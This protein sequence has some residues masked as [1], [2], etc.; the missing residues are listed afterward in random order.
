MSWLNLSDI[1]DLVS[2]TLYGDDVPITCVGIDSRTIG[3]GALFIA[4]PGVRFD[5]HD[6]A[7][8]AAG[9]GAVALLVTHKLN[10]PM[11]QVLVKDT[12]QALWNLACEWRKQLSLRMI[13]L[14]G[15]NGKTTTKEMLSSIFRQERKVLSTSGNLNNHIGVPLTLLNLRREHNV[16]V[17]EMGANHS[18]EIG[19]LTQL[20]NP[21][22][23][24]VI[25]AAEAHLEGFGSVDNV[26]RA[27]GELF[28]NLSPDAI[29]VINKDSP[30]YLIWNE[31][32]KERRTISFG[33]SSK[34][35]VSG[36]YTETSSELVIEGKTYPVRLQLP[37]KYNFYNAMAAT[38]VAYAAGI[39]PETIT[40]GL[41][42]C[43]T[44]SGRLH[45]LPGLHGSCLIDDSYNANPASLEAAL[46]VLQS[47][48]QEKWLVLGN[49]QELGQRSVEL[50]KTAG[51]AAKEHGIQRLFT[52]GESAALA[53]DAFGANAKH[54]STLD[55]LIQ[56]LFKEI[57]SD[58]AVL[59]KGSRAAEMDKVVTVLSR[60]DN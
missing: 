12:L 35:D 47:C 27:K 34:A 10:L 51:R 36:R 42:T 39:K 20:V 43:G 24:L 4:V 32:L 6:F 41:E 21:D 29:G 56:C 8:Q 7:K 30:Y 40:A 59:V 38:A 54:F 13:A 14:T 1:N 3:K 53:A 28:E 44:V 11:P 60:E 37:G 17:I 9:A 58:V 19:Q 45:F 50:H 57:H 16:G 2:G 46:S 22:I 25:N 33:I 23:G 18:G 55:A 49:M 52:V 31:L 5:G 48:S 26:A 15:S